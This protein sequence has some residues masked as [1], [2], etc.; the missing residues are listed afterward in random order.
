MIKSG[1]A[2]FIDNGNGTY[3]VKLDGYDY[4]GNNI[5]CNWTGVIEED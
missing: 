3:T 1:S 2:E 5:T 4:K